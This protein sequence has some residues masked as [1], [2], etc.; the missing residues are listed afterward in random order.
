MC[1]KIQQSSQIM[2]RSAPKLLLEVLEDAIKTSRSQDIKTPRQDKA[3][4]L[5]LLCLLAWMDLACLLA[6]KDGRKL[7]LDWIGNSVQDSQETPQGVKKVQFLQFNTIQ[8]N[9]FIFVLHQ[10][11]FMR[12]R[13]LSHFPIQ[14]HFSR[15]SFHFYFSFSSSVFLKHPINFTG[16]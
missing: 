14:N 4:V 6:W 3:E 8:Y 5:A 1:S 11:I 7:C 12:K 2:T 10:S 16:R 9:T 13:T 15:N